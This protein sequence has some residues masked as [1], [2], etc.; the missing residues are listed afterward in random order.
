MVADPIFQ[1]EVPTMSVHTE[2]CDRCHKDVPPF[3]MVGL[4]HPDRRENVCN[5][6]WNAEIASQ[7]GMDFQHPEFTPITMKDVQGTPHT[8]HFR[9]QIVNRGVLVEAL[10]V[11]DSDA[12]GY[13]FAVVGK[14]DEDPIIIFT[15]LYQRLKRELARK[16]IEH[17]EHGSHFAEGLC[18]RGRISM[19]DGD[20]LVGDGATPRVVIDGNEYTWKQFGRMV[21]TC[22]GWHFKM[23]I[24]DRAEE[25]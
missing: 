9:T 20:D 19:D 4:S 15:R 17:A 23:E 21:M 1:P 8:F 11:K 7:A 12:D 25:R 13:E 18:A 6:C 22:E 3:D 24:F 14:D 2:T 5:G 10:E 16:H